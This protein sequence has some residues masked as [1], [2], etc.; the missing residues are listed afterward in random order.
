MDTDVKEVKESLYI[1]ANK[2]NTSLHLRLY[3]SRSRGH[4]EALLAKK[5]LLQVTTHYIYTH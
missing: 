2:S 1:E 3:L 5:E 4:I